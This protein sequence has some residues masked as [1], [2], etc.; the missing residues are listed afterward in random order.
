MLKRNIS[1]NELFDVS[2]ITNKKLNTVNYENV[3]SRIGYPF[4]INYVDGLNHSYRQKSLDVTIRDYSIFGMYESKKISNII[5]PSVSRKKNV[6]YN[7]AFYE[8]FPHVPKDIIIDLHK[9]EID[10]ILVTPKNVSLYVPDT[11]S[12]QY[13]VDGMTEEQRIIKK[14]TQDNI[15][16]SGDINYY[17]NFLQDHLNKKYN[18]PVVPVVPVVPLSLPIRPTTPPRKGPIKTTRT[19]SP[20]T[21]TTPLPFRPITPQQKGPLKTTTGNIIPSPHK[22][23]SK[24]TT[25]PPPPPPIISSSIASSSTPITTNVFSTDVDEGEIVSEKSM[26]HKYNPIEDLYDQMVKKVKSGTVDI[27]AI[28]SNK[29]NIIFNLASDM[30]RIYPDTYEKLST[31]LNDTSKDNNIS[32]EVR[33]NINDLLSTFNKRPI[34][35][36]ISNVR[37]VFKSF[38]KN[39]MKLESKSTQILNDPDLFSITPTKSN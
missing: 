27:S 10:D 20:I 38:V 2:N 11:T 31:I 19:I 18:I 37:T 7:P 5:T 25:L 21:S 33:S 8:L 16:E 24:Y 36:S 6:L 26:G 22:I 30:Q 15:D 32:N 9:S 39:F 3:A 29:N 28:T 14:M 13:D 1:G 4:N 35:S 34:P 17:S 23:I 12:I